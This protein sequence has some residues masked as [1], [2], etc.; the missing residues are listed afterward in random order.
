MGLRVPS[1][2][3]RGWCY[4]KISYNAVVGLMVQEYYRVYK[5]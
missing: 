1:G 5:G 3:S 4:Y 2:I